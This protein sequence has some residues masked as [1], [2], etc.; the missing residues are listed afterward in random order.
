MI[1]IISKSLISLV[2]IL[3]LIVFYLSFFGI[4]TKKFN[5]K[6]KEEV[7]II[8]KKINLEL[9]NINLLLN[10][11]NLTINATTQNPKIL[12]NGNYLNFKSIKTNISLKSF[13]NKE[14]SIDGLNISTKAIKLNDLVSLARSFR[15]SPELFVLDNV[16]KEGFI[17]GNMDLNFDSEGRLKKD[18][19]IDG[20][21]KK[22]KFSLL[23]KNSINNLDLIFQIKKNKYSLK[24]IKTNLNEI[25]LSSPLIE[26]KEKNNLFFI[27]GEILTKEKIFDI[28]E[29]NFIFKENFK[30]LN[31]EK[32]N[33]S[34]VNNFSFNINKRF[35][36]D[37]LDIESKI[38][39]KNLVLKNNSLNIKQ[40]LPNFEEQIKLNNHKIVIKYNK[41]KLDINGKGG[42]SIEDKKDSIKYNIIKENE[43][44]F[45]KTN[46][47]LDQNPLILYFLN[48]KKKEDVNSVIS[49]NGVY[50]KK[51][52]IKFDL[53]SFKENNNEIFI[54]NLNLNNR[55]KI[56]DIKLINL[57]FI[58]NNKIKNQIS[59]KK[60]K[61]NY[62][63]RGK[64]F[65]ATMLVDEILNGDSEESS[66]L[67]SDINSDLLINIEK[68]YLDENTFVNN[69]NGKINFQNNKIH[70]LNLDSIFLNQKKL[71]FTINTN[72][73]NEKI[74]TLFS[75]YPKPLVG[76]YKFIKGFEEGVLDFY[77]IK[78]NGK[79]NSVLKI[80]NFKVQE[81]PVLAKL[82]TLASLQGIAD[83]LTGEGIRFTDFEMKFSNEKKLMKIEEMYAI[84]PAISILMDGYLE[85]KKLI[86]LRGTLVPATTINRTISSIPV[87]GKILVGKKVGEG[88]FGVSFKVKGHPDNL[89]TT[90]NPIKTLT[91]RFITRTLEKIKKN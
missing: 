89:K 57:D 16:I 23:N 47:N 37:N 10:P 74:T 73:N 42:L 82:L 78:K 46:I 71:T 22:G 84:G 62:I 31:I 14:F 70:S 58:N 45:F 48:Y 12:L 51:S 19:Q 2:I 41:K 77:S 55:L 13:I 80:D 56:L 8:N 83:L 69:L 65:D 29:L 75:D 39:L 90:V 30:N 4:N 11:F 79:S 54:K 44:Y 91:P 67:F 81:V 7:L 1:K 15:N 20:F 35:K 43:Q 33:F 3:G 26:I 28:K 24:K 49:I 53:I 6:I 21:I 61:K 86:S 52:L 38:S 17:T 68:N 9:N 25:E 36:L 87:I 50:K 27:N 60:D 63:I 5:N 88:V 66:S 64:S 85:G 18:Y 32:M 34:S 72:N 76:Q 40:Y 59:L